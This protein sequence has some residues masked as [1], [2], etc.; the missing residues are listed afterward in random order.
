MADA[1]PCVVLLLAAGA[2]TRM[3]RPKQLLDV[4]G[5]PLL[6]RAARTAIDAGLHRVLVVLGAEAAR[7]RP[8]VADL[9][10]DIVMNPEWPEGIASS[11]R[12][13]VAAVELDHP[14]ARGLIVMMADQPGITA[15][16]L[17]R[18][19]A[20]QRAG[21]APIVASGYGEFRGPPAYF[22]RGSFAALKSLRG[23]VGARRLLQA[24]AILTVAAPPG[25]GAD[26][27]TPLDCHRLLD[28]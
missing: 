17:G 9:D 13:G 10:L 7:I 14:D 6:R 26:L 4:E 21:D 1:G 23:D 2:S 28:G 24:E 11:L 8:V 3:G 25:S 19:D 12:A 18:I 16:H 15:A 22:G 27:D 20:A 5:Q